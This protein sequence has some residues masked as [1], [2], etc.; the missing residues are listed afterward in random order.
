MFDLAPLAA[1]SL[2]VARRAAVR[3]ASINQT[4]RRLLGYR[5]GMGAKQVDGRGNGHTAKS[6][7]IGP[8]VQMFG[9]RLPRRV[10]VDIRKARRG[11]RL[12]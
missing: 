7:G 10:V 9:V 11:R 4:R 6:Y 8:A 3:S 2:V 5:R 1:Q 12:G